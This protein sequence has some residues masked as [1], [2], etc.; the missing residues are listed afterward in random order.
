MTAEQRIALESLG[1]N[2]EE[3]LERFVENEAL[4]FKCL[5]KL[6][7]DQNLDALRTAI[8][9]RDAH[10][11]F[12]A[13]HALKGVTSNLGLSKVY[14]EIQVITEVFRNNSLDYDK[15]NLD[16]LSTEYFRAKEVIAT[17]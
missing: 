3:T 4:L 9:E 15:D 7:D 6:L 13:A 14:K 8:S 1:M 16:R 11:A 10:K 17:I 2:I 12:E 5:K